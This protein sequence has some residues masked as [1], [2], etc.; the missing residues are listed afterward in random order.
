M[1]AVRPDQTD[2]LRCRSE[3][4]LAASD[5][6]L[7][8]ASSLDPERFALV[9]QRHAEAVGR[10]AARRLGAEAA[11]DIVA[12]TF[13]LAFQQRACYD[14]ARL[15]ARPWLYGIAGNL[16]RRHRRAEVRMFDALARSGFDPVAD[17]FADLTDDRLAAAGSARRIAIA[18]AAL[19]PGQRDVVLL[20]AWADLTYDQVAEA[21]GIPEGTV[22]SRMNRA[23]SQLRAALDP[24]N[25]YDTSCT[26][27]IANA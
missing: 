26:E 18:L 19:N 3:P 25:P 23:R 14:V 10:Y 7:I 16:I 17:S 13:L 22:R 15:D 2:R 20:V 9:F 24:V 6:A 12:E 21:L 11:Q 8:A 4:D 1:S 27:E 5:A